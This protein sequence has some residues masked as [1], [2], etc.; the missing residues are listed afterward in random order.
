[1]KTEKEKMA[2]EERYWAHGEEM[3]GH[4]AKVKPILHKLN[5][6]EYYTD[7]FQDVKGTDGDTNRTFSQ[8]QVSLNNGKLSAKIQTNGGFVIVF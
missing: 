6:T 5:V 1:M 8:K 4:R 3:I 2:A 7:K